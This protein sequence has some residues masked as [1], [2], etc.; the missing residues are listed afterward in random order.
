MAEAIAQFDV[1]GAFWL[2]IKLSAATIVGAGIIGLVI[3][4]MRVAPSSVMRAIGGAYVFIFRNTP[5][6]YLITLLYIG[7]AVTL[8]LQPL[9]PG[10]DFTAQTFFWATIG[11]SLYHAAYVCE[12][13]RSGINTVP[14][15]QAEAARTI[16][17]GFFAALG[18]VILPQALRGA[19]AP[20]G[21]TLVALIKNTT[22]AAAIGVVGP[23]VVMQ[24]MIE[25]RP[26][27]GLWIFL[28]VAI[29]FVIL[30]LPVGALFTWLSRRLAVQR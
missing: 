6:T 8:G 28:I 13:L 4:V 16:G 14:P 24:Q 12:A 1:L 18:L 29:G 30:T 25:F 20:L 9:G 2:T 7:F 11:L 23:S 26:D 21:N 27:L 17:L 15:G 5:L 19:L 22:V 10:A 3:A